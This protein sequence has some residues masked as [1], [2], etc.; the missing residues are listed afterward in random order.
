MAA[1]TLAG[2][3]A[4]AAWFGTT[5]RTVQRW[6][7]HEG[8]P[9]R[10]VRRS[11][12]DAVEVE[13]QELERWVKARSKSPWLAAPKASLAVLP[14]VCRT[15]PWLGEELAAEVLQTLALVPGL[16]VYGRASTFGV[17]AGQPEPGRAVAAT[18]DVST[19]LEGELAPTNG[20]DQWRLGFRLVS[21]EGVVMW[22]DTW[23]ASAVETWQR[24][25]ELARAIASA[26][27]LRLPVQ[28]DSEPQAVSP[29]AFEKWLRARSLFV[30]LEA[31]KI[32]QAI[33]LAEEARAESPGFAMVLADLG[34]YHTQTAFMGMAPV[35]AAISRSEEALDTAQQL[36]PRNA[37]AWMWSARNAGLFRYDWP[38]AEQMFRKALELAPA[39]PMA[40][41]FFADLL[42]TLGRH[43]EALHYARRWQQADGLNPLGFLTIAQI[44]AARGDFA[45]ARAEAERGLS[46]QPHWTLVWVQGAVLLRLERYEE[47]Y[48]VLQAAARTAP[49]HCWVEPT[50]ANACLLT[51]RQDELR[52]LVRRAESD[53]QHFPAPASTLGLLHAVAGQLEAALGWLETALAERDPALVFQPRASAGVIVMPEVERPVYE[54]PRWRAIVAAMGLG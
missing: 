27:R 47:A 7:T 4:I 9:V 24:R 50:Y 29:A 52:E 26:L 12:R 38:A 46:I 11:R 20:A 5:V 25:H 16:Q 14:F 39:H 48:Q 6:E 21:R 10:R 54:H 23:E 15:Q 19:W 37:D 51:G 13:I 2:W 41:F 49:P 31:Q 8:L 43:E 1:E 22:A 18:L 17:A 44:L 30:T 45:A 42:R 28:L 34:A 35:A 36:A 3:K 32:A 53:R 40:S 33:A